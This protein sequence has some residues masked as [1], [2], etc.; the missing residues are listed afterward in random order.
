MLFARPDAVGLLI[1]Q[2]VANP[3]AAASQAA[4]L[5][6]RRQLQFVFAA[7]VLL[8]SSTILRTLREQPQ[9]IERLWAFVSRP[10]PLDPVQLQYW[11]RVSGCLLLQDGGAC[12][13]G[14]PGSPAGKR[15]G[16]AAEITCGFW[17]ALHQSVNFVRY[18]IQ[19]TR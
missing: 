7:S 16:S 14:M 15:S 3:M 17:R 12:V 6:S 19:Y 18:M 1:A 10:A 4:D 8:T 9:L 13:A 11:C 5:H 2:L